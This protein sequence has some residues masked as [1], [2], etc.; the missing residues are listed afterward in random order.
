[1]WLDGG[2]RPTV[3]H[4]PCWPDDWSTAESRARTPE[5]ASSASTGPPKSFNLY[6]IVLPTGAQRVHAMYML[7]LLVNLGVLWAIVDT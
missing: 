5:N 4:R 7:M 6:R 1:M 3:L 2:R